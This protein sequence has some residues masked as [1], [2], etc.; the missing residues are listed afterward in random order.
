VKIENI[1]VEYMWFMKKLSDNL[2]VQS[3]SLTWP[4]KSDNRCVSGTWSTHIVR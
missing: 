1:N 2:G 3:E 4:I